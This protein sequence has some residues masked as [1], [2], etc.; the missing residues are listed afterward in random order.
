MSEYDLIKALQSEAAPGFP[1]EPLSQPLSLFRMHFLLFHL[2]Y[3]LRHRL[4]EQRQNTL[5]I[6][7]L[8]ICLR[9]YAPQASQALSTADPVV[10]YYA[11]FDHWYTTT[12]EN[13]KEKLANFWALMA[14]RS[15]K[16]V[17]LEVLGLSEPVDYA[18][19]KQRYRS[20][21]MQQHPDQGGDTAEMQRLNEAMAVLEKCYLR[22]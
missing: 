2:L 12:E 6:Q 13:V 18:E 16:Q 10:E 11:D 4:S 9:P 3:G 17:A 21:A 20:L 14:A 19:I 8:Q 22:S 15:D 7:A 1:D 5:D